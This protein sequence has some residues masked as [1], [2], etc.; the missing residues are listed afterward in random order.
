MTEVS[1]RILYWTPRILGI[2]FALFLSLFALD[3]FGEGLGFWRT[4]LALFMHLIPVFVVLAVIAL[5]WRWEWVGFVFLTALGFVYIRFASM[6]HFGWQPYALI[7]GPLFLVALLFL[8]NWLK[9][10]ELKAS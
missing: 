4:L 2:A 6:R 5:A 10:R 3:V 8:I 9:R 1:K 7:S